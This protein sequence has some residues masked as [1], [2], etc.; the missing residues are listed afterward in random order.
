[1]DF[2]T[3]LT[4]HLIAKG[5]A[6]ELIRAIQEAR[7]AAGCRLDEVIA[8]VLPDWPVEFEAYLKQQTLVGRITRGTTLT[9]VRK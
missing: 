3:E 6:R 2:D 7:K 9:V 1:V 4:P 5:K 8:V